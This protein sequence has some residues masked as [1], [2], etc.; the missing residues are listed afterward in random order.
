MR[1]HFTLA[2]LTLACAASAAPVINE[3]YF[4]PP[5][6][7]EPAGEEWLEIRNP[8][9]VAVDVSGWSFSKGVSFTIPAAT[10]IPAGGYL[11]VAANVAAFNSANPGF[12]GTVIGGWTGTLANGG[13][14]L[15]LD[16]ALGNKVCDL[17]Y[18]DEGEWAVRGRGDL[19]FGH[20]GWEWFCAADG[21]GKSFELR[22][23]ALGIGS[24]QNWGVSAA[25]GGSPGAVN[26][27]A[28]ANVA[29]LIKD[30]KHRPE[31]PT[32]T[33]AIVVSCN[34][35]DE[36]PGAT[37][38]LHWRLDAGAWAMLAMTDGD[39]DGDV[40][41]SI[42]AQAN[43]AIVEWYISATDGVN[44][45]TWPAAARTSNPGVLPETFGQVTN[46]L[47]LVDNSFSATATFL[48]PSD[49][50]VYR[51]IMTGVDRNELVQIGT[52]N[53]EQESL[54]TF[55]ATF[56]SHDGTGIKAI[57]NCG[58]RNRGGGDT[59]L[60]P[61]NNYSVSFRSD[62]KWDGRGTMTINAYFPHSQALGNALF[63]RA[64]IPP[65]EAAVVRVRLNGVDMAESGGRMLGRYARL[66]GR[67]ADWAAHHY[68]NDAEGNFYRVD[69]HFPTTDN[70]PAENLGIGEFRYEGTNGA[71]YA[72]GYIKQTNQAQAD[73]S[74]VANL[75]RIISAPETGG[76]AGQPAISNAAYPAAV[77]TVL[78]VDQ[79]YRYIATDALIGNQE[80]G[81]Q[82]GRADDFSLYRGVVDTRFRFV[83]H[84]M[85]D[86][87]DI[88]AGAGD[89]ITRSLFSYDEQVQQGNTGVVGLRRM[90]NHPAMVPRYYAAVLDAMNSWFNHATIDP[91]IDQIMTGWV[92]PATI[93][94]TKGYIDLRRANVLTQIQQ[95]YAL[96]VTTAGAAIEG[97]SR[98]TNG[99]AT[100][101]GTF[102]VAKTYSITVNGVLATWSY[103]NTGTAAGDDD[104]GE[105]F[106]TVPA[107]GGSVLTPGLNTV[108]VRFW[109]G[110]NS[111]GAI[112]N[113][114]TRQ[115]IWEPTTAVYTSVS[116]TLA[117]SGTLAITTPSSYIPGI[118]FL[119]RVD[120]KDGAGNLDRT[121]WNRTASLT[122]TN[123][124]TLTPNTVTLTNGMGSALVTVGGGG[125][126]VVPIFTYGTGGTGSTAANTGTVGSTWKYRGDF[127]STTLATFN[128]N[129]GATWKNEGFDDSTWPS[130]VT[131]TGYGDADENRAFTRVD[132]DTVAAGT[133]SGPT[134]LF[135]NTFTIADV[136]QLVSV[137]GQVKF[138]DAAAVYVNGTQ[139]LRTATLPAATPLTS[140][141][142]ATPTQEN[143][144]SAITVPLGLLHNGVN[145]IAVEIHQADIGS[146]D[147]TFDL[148]LSS[149]VT[150]GAADPGN[151]TLTSTVGTLNS[152]KAI[153]SLTPTPTMTNVSGTLPAGV[154]TWSGVMNVTGDVTV[155]ATGTLNISPGTIV[156]MAGDATAGSSAGSDLIVTTG[157]GVNALGTAAQPISITANSAANRWGE[158][159]VNGSTTNWQ[160]CLVT[161]AAH[162][163]GG[164]HTGTGPAFRLTNGA[165]WTFDDGAIT[166]LPGKTLTNSGN[167]TMTMRRSHFA[168]CVMGPETDG[169]AITIEDSNFSEMLSIYRETGAADDEDCIYIHDSGGRPVNLRRSVFSNAGDD[170]ID[171]LAG[172]VTV[173]DCIVR[174]IND[175]GM[176]LLQNNVTVRRTQIVDCDFGI[177]TKTQ[178]GSEATPYTLTMENVTI[179]GESHPGNQ[180]DQSGGIY[181]HNVG[182]H[183]RNKYGTGPNAQLIVNA[184]NCIISA[185]TPMLNDYGTVGNDFPLLTST[186]NCYENVAGTNP[187]DP[188]APAG[189]GDIAAV[190]LFVNAVAKDFHLQSTSPARD[191]GDPASPLDSD[192]SRADMGALPFGA[193]GATTGAL[194]WTPAGGPY[195]VTANATVPV[196]LTLTVQ[197]GTAVYFD[198]N[199]RLTVNGKMEVLGTPDKRISFSHVPGTNVTDHDV[200]P[201]KNL[202]QYGAP[203]WGGIRV[204][205]SMNV[206]SVFKY[207]D[208]INAQ[209]ISPSTD[210][211]GSLGFVRSWGFCE[212]LT[213]AGTHLRMLYGRNPKLTVIKCIFPDMMIFDPALGRVEDNTDFLTSAD[214]SMEPLKVEYPAEAAST[215]PGWTPNGLP[216]GG[217]WRVYYNQF[218]GN[219]GHNDVFDGDSGSMSVAGDFLLDCRYNHFRGLS[220]D[221]HIDLGGDAYIASNIFEAATKDEWVSAFGTDNGYSNAISSGDKGT[222][223]TIFVVRNVCYDLDHV[224]NCK[225]GTAAVFEH[226]TVANLHADYTYTPSTPDQD[227]KNAPINFFVPEDGSNPTRGDGA[228]MGYNI[229]SN[230]P[231]LFSGPDARKINGTTIV[232]DVTTKI[233]FYHNLLDQI[234]D[235]I[236]GPNH[237]Q[238]AF[239]G[240]YG[241]NVA[242]VPRFNNP[243]AE[244]YGIQ[245][246]SDAR[247]SAFGGLDYGATVP[248]WAYIIGGP[249]GTTD[250]T[251]ATFTVG[252]PGIIAYKWR[253]DGGAWSAEDTVG[254]GG[255]FPRTVGVPCVRQENIVLSGLTPGVHTLEVLGRDM[256]G[257]WQDNDPARTVIGAAQAT[258]T[259]RTWT[260]NTAAPLV[261]INEVLANSAT[262][263]DQVELHNFGNVPVTLTGW[264]LTDDALVPA[265]FPLPVTTI[266]AGGFTTFS[267]ALLGLDKDGDTVLLYQ[268][269]TLRDSV[270]FGA[271]VADMTI[272][273]VLFDNALAWKLGTPTLGA[274]N[275]WVIT[276]EQS[277]I[278]VSEWF[279]GGSVLYASDWIELSNS[280]AFPVDLAGLRITDTRAEA[281][282]VHV[283]PPLSFIAANGFLK[284][285]ADGTGGNRLSFSL[286]EQQDDIY[287]ADSTGAFLDSV[288]Y[289]QQTSEWSQGRNG[290]TFIQYELPTGGLANTTTD[291]NALALL[292]GLRI[293]EIMFNALGGQDFEYVELT[294]IGGTALQLQNVKFVQGITFTFTAPTTLNAGESIVVVKNLTKFRSRYG[295]APVIAGTYTGNLDNSGE[296]VAIQL[297]PP[298]DANILTFAYGDSWRLSADG[299]G[300]ALTTQAGITNASLW[301]D[302]DT[303]TATALGGSPAATGART[304]TFSGWMTLNGVNA[305]NDDNDFDGVPAL[306]ESA[307]GMNPNNGNGTHGTAGTPIAASGATYTFYVPENASAAQGHGVTDLIYTV[308][309]RADLLAGGWTTIAT[310]SFGTNWTGTVS[311]GA[312]VSGFIPVTVTDP[313]GGPQRF[314]HLT[315]TWAP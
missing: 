254:T 197:A 199:V 121:A 269:A 76:T 133:Q 144:T 160:Y 3:I 62:A 110:L 250:Q 174:N 241:P 74:D 115:V 9:A 77:A 27:V 109:G 270:T 298:F 210:N 275:N 88:G 95:N 271:Q 128:T 47:V 289:F 260:V 305:I 288:Q 64:G 7:I 161:R 177:S 227:V 60:G 208:F 108:V 178:I 191:T 286:S 228:Y 264:S 106:L 224:I 129:F 42:P 240:A 205:D 107:G 150:T 114:I 142:N 226:N 155:P 169:S 274:A 261:R 293:S 284:I 29:P 204:T 281:A 34:L 78:D 151:F 141:A 61:P 111:T 280:L 306:I 244:D 120:V 251:T 162:S 30:A 119:V 148:N 234:L 52:T 249:V 12:A 83:P 18:A 263:A 21:D 14:Q 40:E 39:G 165:V 166:D 93:T 301:G 217:W 273:R 304:D 99:A 277:G 117:P 134:Y 180:G 194:V 11:V 46:A 182:V 221:E 158:I 31:I 81:L 223:T 294:N 157:G 187:V 278:R 145:T 287:L 310:K 98:T 311:L 308:Q 140:Y 22:N 252:G 72:D 105:W 132:Y 92:P 256:A 44:S 200:D 138:D 63:L 102:N 206:E 137:T 198:E 33:Q 232:N 50:P 235:P 253:L 126:T 193:S 266:P 188:T 5:G 211:Q 112:V 179:V 135:R 299:G 130:I 183:V 96:T 279:T 215:G 181:W 192:S 113:E 163:P 90:F 184:K 82:S 297:P 97:I 291:A 302:K 65:Q 242:G 58:T 20:R 67:N 36:A 103:R 248:E 17:K 79:F 233:E 229:I 87:F 185:I 35:E 222:G 101:S 243:A 68:P 300:T 213:F 247:R 32:S 212:G 189:T 296:S 292:R 13:E 258:P 84:D 190:P 156:L 59:A 25:A 282:S 153:T 290:S 143:A 312:P 262:L 207:C 8:D 230:V 100:F 201:I 307:L 38:T 139:I 55:N 245:V 6:V 196:G 147:V 159:N 239:S 15:Q 255:P 23:P 164:G 314:F 123:G 131:Q 104:A 285:I 267:S 91:M 149:T 303:W 171:L 257:N 86:V 51:I 172:A 16:D 219:R 75:T 203:K 170:G 218:N 295:N 176:S 53:G 209:G 225:A 220:G 116:G 167:T 154:T 45:R 238:S 4:R 272:G 152:S 124:I 48:T 73:Y 246:T 54:A 175:K 216:L 202:V 313:S 315:I 70:V 265:K 231:R 276:G 186:Y 57:H 94:S 283:I 125:S 146:S 69:D 10:T 89:P 168:R 19:T 37:A 56:V 43:L 66:E 259:V 118:P 1:I 85:D 127:T 136:A 28:S 24:G 80:G 71:N 236:V 173:E 49:S 268:G 237:S 309:S 214:N 41:A 122:A 26:S 195:R 2:T